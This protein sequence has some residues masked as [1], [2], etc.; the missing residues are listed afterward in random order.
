ME[1]SP[2]GL[3]P[4]RNFVDRCMAIRPEF[5]DASDPVP[6]EARVQDSGRVSSK[7]LKSLR[8]PLSAYGKRIRYV[9]YNDFKCSLIP[10]LDTSRPNTEVM[11]DILCLSS[12][13]CW[14]PHPSTAKDGPRSP[15]PSSGII[16]CSMAS[17]SSMARIRLLTPALH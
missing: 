14:I 5:N 15:R 1:R 10:C 2:N 9:L 3:V 11:L 8:P 13:L 4:A 12:K 17:L 7:Q 6:M 16:R